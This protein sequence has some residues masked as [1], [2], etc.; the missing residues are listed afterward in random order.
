MDKSRQTSP[1]AA[2]SARAGQVENGYRQFL[3]DDFDFQFGHARDLR[4]AESPFTRNQNVF[5]LRFVPATDDALQLTVHA[6]AKPSPLGLAS[7]AVA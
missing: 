6:R 5:L 4:S 3:L 1:Q 2:R 7:R